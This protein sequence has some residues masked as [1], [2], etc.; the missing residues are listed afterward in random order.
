MQQPQPK[1]QTS[2]KTASRKQLIEHKVN[3]YVE[4]AKSPT[5]Q[6]VQTSKSP[7]YQTKTIEGPPQNKPGMMSSQSSKVLTTTKKLTPNK[8]YDILPSS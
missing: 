4:K 1:E 3:N 7:T 8:R 6:K 5:N 2:A